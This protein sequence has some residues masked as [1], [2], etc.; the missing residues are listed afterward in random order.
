MR[1]TVTG[2]SRYTD[3]SIS[4]KQQNFSSTQFIQQ[5]FSSF[6]IL[7]ILRLDIIKQ[8][9]EMHNFQNISNAVQRKTTQDTVI[10]TA[11]VA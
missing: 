11:G 2:R 7:P 9:K 3:N 1:S 10:K 8:T 4:F 5:D 6:L